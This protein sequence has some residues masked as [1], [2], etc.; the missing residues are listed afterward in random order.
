[1]ALSMAVNVAIARH[2]V[3]TRLG[4]HHHGGR[5]P[6]VLMLELTHAC[7]LR[8]NGCG[9]IREYADSRALSLSREQARE[10]V[11]EADV[12]VVS[13]SGGEPFLHPDLPGITQD[14]L[15]MGKAVYVCTNATLL[16]RRL[17]E[18]QPNRR[19][20]LNVHLDGPP[21]IHDALTNAP[22]TTE[23]ALE[24]IREAKAAG[25]GVTTNTTL[26]YDT[27]VAELAALFQ[28]L[29]DLGVDGF[30]LAPAFAYEVGAPARTLTREEAHERFRQLKDVWGDK[31]VYHTPIFMEFLRGERELECMPWG[32]VTYNPLGWK[33]PCYLLSDGHAASLAELLE[34][35]DWDRYGHGRDPRCADC[36]MHSGFELSVMNSMHGPADLWKI[37]R[38][39]LMG[40]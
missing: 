11:K 7:N 18:F 33:R 14:I 38:W 29:V 16:S 26:Y 17:A 27:P 4:N 3:R 12:P 36:M 6:M 35:T 5:W 23:R 13:I 10:A 25:F 2:L 20:Y 21:S 39:T 24:A 30:A 31:N 19:L 8:C 1:M 40:E 15:N 28:K 34:E 32:T 22:G 9:R 37:A